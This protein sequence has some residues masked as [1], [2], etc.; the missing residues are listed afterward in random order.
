MSEFEDRLNSL[1]SS[2]EQM[3]R[4]MEF[5]QSFKNSRSDDTAAPKHEPSPHSSAA[6]NLSALDPKLLGILSR[7]MGEYSKGGGEKAEL[8]RS[9]KPFLKNDKQQRLDKALEITKLAHIARI[10]LGEYKGGDKNV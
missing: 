2:P 6:P 4:I 8:I 3:S 7:V 9:M 5:A 10:A 1:L